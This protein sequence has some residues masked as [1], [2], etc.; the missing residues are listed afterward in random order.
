MLQ[1]GHSFV[2]VVADI[3]R[4][5]GANDI[6]CRACCVFGID[7]DEYATLKAIP[8]S[9]IAPSRYIDTAHRYCVKL[10]PW[11][12]MRILGERCTFF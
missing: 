11:L 12:V 7:E 4:G 5:Y 10:N 1:D 6:S 8:E 2:G 9:E 3:S